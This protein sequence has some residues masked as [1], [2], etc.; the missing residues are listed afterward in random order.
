[1]MCISTGHKSKVME[2]LAKMELLY[3]TKMAKVAKDGEVDEYPNI[4]LTH[5]KNMK[6]S[7]ILDAKLNAICKELV[8]K[9]ENDEFVYKFML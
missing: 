8:P 2:R 7:T 3:W 5:L 1:M 6:K 9:I 4:L